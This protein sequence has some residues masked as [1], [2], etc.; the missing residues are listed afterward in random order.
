MKRI[1]LILT[2][3]L[4]PLLWGQNKKK[5]TVLDYLEINTLAYYEEEKEYETLKTDTI[6][7]K[8]NKQGTLYFIDINK[9]IA[10]PL[11]FNEHHQLIAIDST[12]TLSYKDDL[13]HQTKVS[14]SDFDNRKTERIAYT[15]NNERLLSLIEFTYYTSRIQEPFISV[16]KYEYDEK[17]RII[18]T[19][20]LSDT[21]RNKKNII[22]K[23]TVFTYDNARNG[24][25]S[26]PFFST[27]IIVGSD[28][29]NLL[30]FTNYKLSNNITSITNNQEVT[31][32][33]YTYDKNNLPKTAFMYPAT[34][35]FDESTF[36]TKYIYHYKEIE[37]IE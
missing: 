13:L 6:L 35:E 8:Y 16:Y 7:F 27:N 2:L 36:Y 15:Y 34:K 31:K 4:P 32:I 5:I 23:K 11:T 10:L 29:L 28:E 24:F 9:E 14:S 25:E 17:K 30:M 19:T 20:H 3:L 33:D 21:E 26:I 37:I 18:A 22:N 12:I 1:L